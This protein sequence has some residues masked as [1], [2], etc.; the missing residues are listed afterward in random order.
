MIGCCPRVCIHTQLQVTSAFRQV[1]FHFR[2]SKAQD[3][4]P[5]PL[6]FPNK[7]NTSKHAT[8]APAHTQTITLRPH[9][10]DCQRFEQRPVA[11]PQQV[12]AAGA[13]GGQEGV[14]VVN[15]SPN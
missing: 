8:S 7:Y 15:T 1:L 6:C 11:R 14:C 13:W 12:Q 9:L 2:C 3:V 10:Q 5:F 4:G